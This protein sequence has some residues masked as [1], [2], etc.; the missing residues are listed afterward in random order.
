MQDL[1]R[2]LAD[3]GAIR[4]QLARGTEF[5][6][7]G[8][9]TVAATGG[10]AVIG[11]LCQ[12]AWLEA[13]VEALPRYLTLWIGIAAVSILL[14]GAEM[15]TRSR[16][17]H[18]ALADEMVAAAV[19]QF[20]PALAAGTLL[21]AVLLRY[22]PGSAALLP[23]LWQVMFALGIF[24]SAR[25]LPRVTVLAAAWYLVCGLA[26]IALARGEAALSPWCMGVPFGAGQLGSAVLLHRALGRN[27]G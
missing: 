20:V 23:G 2:A 24:A 4:T 7:L 27:R 10:L 12:G 3:I 5:R 18:S 13:P 9:A 6:G 11:A 14:A 8:P 25:F 16:R 19:G 1:D 22:V 26:V 21:T 17:L 15:V